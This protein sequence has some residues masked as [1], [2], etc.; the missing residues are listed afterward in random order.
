MHHTNNQ[1][2]AEIPLPCFVLFMVFGR[3]DDPLVVKAACGRLGVGPT[4]L[5]AQLLVRRQPR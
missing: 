4:G 2:K 3:D 1:Q 5:A